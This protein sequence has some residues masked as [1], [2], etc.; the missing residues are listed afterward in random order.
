MDAAGSLMQCHPAMKDPAIDPTSPRYLR[1]R[2][3]VQ[4][5]LATICAEMPVALFTEM[6]ERIAVVQLAYEGDPIDWTVARR[7]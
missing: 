3:E 6:V 1:I 2:S 7:R 4:A 5:R